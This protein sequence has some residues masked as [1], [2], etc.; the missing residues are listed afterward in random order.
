MTD[1]PARENALK[2]YTA[3]ASSYVLGLIRLLEAQI[4]A[5]K[6]RV[7]LSRIHQ[8]SAW[9]SPADEELQ[10]ILEPL[11]SVTYRQY[12]AFCYLT[13]LSYLIYG[14]TL[15]DSFLSDTTKLLF[16]L[17]PASMG[18]D[19]SV[20]LDAV[21]SAKSR[22]ELI[23]T[24]ATK[25]VRELSFLGFMHRVEFL[26]ETFGLKVGLDATTVQAIEHY[27]SLRNVVVHDQSVFDVTLESGGGVVASQKSCPRHPTP[28]KSDDLEGAERAYKEV[29]KAV[30]EAV[31]TH[32]FKAPPLAL[33]DVP[34]ATAD[35]TAGPRASAEQVRKREVDDSISRGQANDENPSV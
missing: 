12:D 19:V 16:L 35:D 6:A 29:V 4:A 14:T 27:S 3:L 22:E 24:M 26:N 34:V 28:L 32:V 21:I 25:K 33:F 9:E 5:Y 23:G 8:T 30:C 11:R 15:L 10:G 13:E 31:V 20:K 1:A 2:S 7:S 17:F 18:S